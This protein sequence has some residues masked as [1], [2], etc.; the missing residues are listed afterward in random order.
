[1]NLKQ[2]LNQRIAQLG[3]KKLAIEAYLR[4]PKS[5]LGKPYTKEDLMI[6][7]CQI[8]ETEAAIKGIENWNKTNLYVETIKK[9]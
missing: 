3:G 6:V 1:M 8:L 9:V 2:I 5:F 4:N 7:D